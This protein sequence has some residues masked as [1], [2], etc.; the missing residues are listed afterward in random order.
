MNSSNVMATIRDLNETE[1]DLDTYLSWL[2]DV[3]GNPFIES[4]RADYSMSDLNDF[5]ASKLGRPD[6]RFWAIFTELD[7]FIGTVKLDPIDFIQGNAWLG[8]MIGEVSQRGKGYGQMVLEQV[9]Q[10]S[11]VTLN[12][13][14]LLLG[15]HKNNLAAVQL[16]KKQGFQIIETN[17]VSFVMKK[18]LTI[19][20]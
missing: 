8:I 10:Y 3:Y 13:R 6:V 16:Y 4:A 9:A 5:L 2:Q 1:V 15:V 17:E 12:L 19:L 18:D 14:K 7:E 20:T 11:L